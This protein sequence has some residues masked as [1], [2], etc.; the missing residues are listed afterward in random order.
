MARRVHPGLGDS[1]HVD[2]G[3]E[4]TVSGAVEPV[5]GGLARGNLQGRDSHV[6][7]EG[8]L[9]TEPARACDLADQM[10]RGDGRTARDRHQ[11]RSEP[12]HQGVELALKGPDLGREVTAGS[13]LVKGDASQSAC[14][15]PFQHGL[16]PVQPDV[17]I[18]HPGRQIEP[19]FE[20]VAVPAQARLDAFALVNEVV[21]V[22]GQQAHV[23][24]GPRER[25]GGKTRFAQCGPGHTG[26]IDGV[27]LA[28]AACRVPRS[29][30]HLGWDPDHALASRQQVAFETSRD[31]ATVLDREV[32][33][34]RQ[35]P[36]PR[37]QLVV[38]LVACRH[39]RLGQAASRS[40]VDR[41][42]RV[43]LH[44]G[45]YPDYDHE[46]PLPSASRPW[47][48]PPAD[49]PWWGPL[50][51]APIRSRRRPLGSRRRRTQQLKVSPLGRQ[52]RCGSLR[53]RN[54]GY[55]TGVRHPARARVTP[56]MRWLGSPP[57]AGY[58]ERIT[59]WSEARPASDPRRAPRRRRTWPSRRG[60][61]PTLR[62]T[63]LCPIG[64]GPSTAEGCQQAGLLAG[65]PTI[66]CG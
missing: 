63:P 58:L 21:S 1:D 52:M 12:T 10:R 29:G 6:H 59:P 41:D 17:A 61:I 4:T 42:C 53:R 5:T 57:R 62:V 45:V 43:G 60:G 8:G 23:V 51:Q 49:T 39:R 24:F 11:V 2:G 15:Q 28:V 48:G 31:V 32:A 55:L 65:S 64:R 36:R 30:H 27:G 38:S 44:V 20:V 9:R 35:P 54:R 18:Q 40:G 47:R 26:R 56:T 19:D 33:V 16:E 13:Q 3:V 14:R 7:R 34:T 66:R 50:G 46:R 22:V 37:Q 25:R